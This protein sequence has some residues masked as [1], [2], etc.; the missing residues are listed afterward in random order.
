MTMYALRRKRCGEEWLWAPSSSCV[1][2]KKQLTR[3]VDRWSGIQE[4]TCTNPQSHSGATQMVGDGS[5]LARVFTN[6]CGLIWKVMRPHGCRWV[7]RAA[8]V[9]LF[10]GFNSYL[11]HLKELLGCTAHAQSTKNSHI[12]DVDDLTFL[13]P[14]HCLP[15]R[16]VAKLMESCYPSSKRVV[17]RLFF[18]IQIHDKRAVMQ[19]VAVVTESRFTSRI[20]VQA[21]KKKK[22]RPKKQSGEEKSA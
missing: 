8:H 9:S 3:S 4:P 5:V 21:Q 13:D 19:R 17:W 18:W 6:R 14:P 1:T 7:G 12:A 22:K 20:H 15:G 16:G 2:P 11:A 10:A